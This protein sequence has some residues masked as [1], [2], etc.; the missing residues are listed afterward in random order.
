MR[1]STNGATYRP[2]KSIIKSY[3]NYVSLLS[4]NVYKTNLTENESKNLSQ[5]VNKHYTERKQNKLDPEYI[6]A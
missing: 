6:I 4:W 3:V 2:R 1:Y 5:N